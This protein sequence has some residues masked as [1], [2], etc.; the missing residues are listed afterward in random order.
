LEPALLGSN[1]IVGQVEAGN[2]AW[3]VNPAA[4]GQPVSRFTWTSASGSTNNFPNAVGFESDHANQVGTNF[5]GASTGVAPGVQRVDVFEVNYFIQSVVA[6]QLAIS[7][8]IVNQSFAT[9]SQNPSLDQAYDDYAANRATLFVS[10]AGNGG[11]LASP[12]T[13]YNGIAVG[14]LGGGSSVGPTPLGGRAK[15]DLTVTG[16]G[17]TAF[18]SFSTPQVAGAAA[19]LMQAAA[20]GDAGPGTSVVAQDRRL[21]KALLLN[22]AV[23]PFDWTNGPTR[24]L[25]ARYGAGILNVFNS[26]SHLRGGLR[27][28]SVFTTDMTGSPPSSIAPTNIASIRRCW[29]LATISNAS[30]RDAAAHYFFELPGAP[31]RRYRLTATLVWEKQATRTDINDLDLL[32]FDGTSHLLITNSASRVDNVEH[33]VAADLPPGVYDVQVVKSGVAARRIT[34]TETYALVIDFGPAE[35]AHL[36]NPSFAAGEFSATAACIPGYAYRVEA[37]V[38][39]SNWV[40]VVTNFPS[41]SGALNFS[42]PSSAGSPH[43]FY[44]ALPWP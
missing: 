3:E 8:R 5:Y 13:A 23:K 28:A 16:S 14:V 21:F 25:D 6:G 2:P 39:F 29:S 7:P 41:L 17:A 43:R 4:V 20:R 36:T 31:E 34:M 10:G 32:V 40:G 19:I 18:T 12:A 30:M 24:P 1:V 26:Y 38:D 44:R 9:T 33:L 15:P 22:G 27:F 37:T 35:G 42:D 11:A